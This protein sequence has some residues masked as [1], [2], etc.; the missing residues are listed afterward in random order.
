MNC[1]SSCYIVLS[2]ALNEVVKRV[3]YGLARGEKDF[4]L[5]SRMILIAMYNHPSWNMQDTLR[6]CQSHWDQG[7]V[8]LDLCTWQPDNS[9]IGNYLA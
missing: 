6:L 5:Q 4:G 9:R 2:S 1:T 7:V 8:G 3:S